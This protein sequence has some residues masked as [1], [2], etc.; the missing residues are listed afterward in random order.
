MMEHAK[1]E[2]EF[3][4]IQPAKPSK[5]IRKKFLSEV[6]IPIPRDNKACLHVNYKIGSTMYT[7]IKELKLHSGHSIISIEVHVSISHIKN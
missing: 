7:S 1:T 3:T 2:E 5:E 4:R 6:G